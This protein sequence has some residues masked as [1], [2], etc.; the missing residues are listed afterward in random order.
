MPIGLALKFGPYIVIFLM[1]AY[2]MALRANN[3]VLAIER[4]TA[5]ANEEILTGEI[6]QQNQRIEDYVANQAASQIRIAF[7]EDEKDKAETRAQQQIQDLN[8][9]RSKLSNEINARP[10]VVERAA[11]LRFRRVLLDIEDATS[12]TG[13]GQDGG[14]TGT[15]V[16][17]AEARSDHSTPD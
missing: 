2:I 16:S 12:T 8:A 6:E 9:W 4:D 14:D 1:A 17:P 7:L 10:E 15:N 11:S 5:V 3:D 13:G